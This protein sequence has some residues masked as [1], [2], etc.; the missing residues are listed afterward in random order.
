MVNL[1]RKYRQGMLTVITV[2][3]I[4]S[5]AWLY[6]DY[7]LGGRGDGGKVG[8]IYGRELYLT[9]Y[10]HGLRRFQ[11]CQELGLFELLGGLAGSAQTKEKAEENFVFGAYVLR[12]EADALGVRPTDGEVIESIKAMPPFQ[13]NG[14]YDSSKWAIYTQRLASFGFTQDQIEEAV[15]DNLKLQKLKDLVG[16]TIS[17]PASELRAAF[18]EE[19]Q[20]VEV[21]YVT[22]K[23]GDLAKEIQIS[24]EDLKKAFDERKSGF[25]T[26]Q[27]RVVKYVSLVLNDEEKK[28]QGKDRAA[29]LQKLV[30]KASD[31][32]V[33][34]TVKDAKLEEVAEKAGLKVGTTPP[35][36]RG[37]PPAELGRSSAATAAAFD[38]I[39]EEQRNSDPVA[40]ER[41]DGYYI[42]QLVSITPPRDQTFDE[43]KAKLTETLKRERVSE[44]LAAKAS[45][46]RAKLEAEIKAGKSFADAAQ[47]VNLPAEKI[48]AF[49]AAEP[50]K[51]DNP[52]ARAIAQ[53]TG[54]LTEGSLSEV[55]PVPAGRI[56]FHVDKRLPIDEAAFEKEKSQIAENF[57]RGR[58]ESAF[59]LWFDER[60]KASNLQ[61]KIGQPA[62][63]GA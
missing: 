21:S 37:T 53:A 51:Q 22:I 24:D 31:F 36:S 7:R 26:D 54:D 49:S 11:M 61:S 44:K 1:M 60:V 52:A 19:N 25:K 16:T 48:P 13:T 12:H 32:S 9:D 46:V 40:S 34:M 5:F 18:E 29:A 50:P 42:M 8:T 33:A 35:F 58:A 59:R 20:K 10:Q 41:R 63:P 56:V 38:K 57:S 3:I 30:D 55:L 27:L 2:I 23:E 15:R 14:A 17:A 39:S 43:V 28:L 62:A 47:A 4:I 45:E 6:N